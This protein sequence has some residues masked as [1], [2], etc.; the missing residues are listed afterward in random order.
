MFDKD[1][2]I[3]S[4]QR[5]RLADNRAGQMPSLDRSDMAKTVDKQWAGAPAGYRELP[6]FFSTASARARALGVKR[7]TIRV[8]DE[9][10]AR[11][12]RATSQGRV[13]L[14]LAVCA[15]VSK[16]LVTTQDVGRWMLSPQP[17]LRGQSPVEALLDLGDDVIQQIRF[18]LDRLVSTNGSHEPLANDDWEAI[19]SELDPA[20]VRQIRSTY[21]RVVR[22]AVPADLDIYELV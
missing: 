13:A 2:S 10:R 15:A 14:L 12:V 3:P 19:E 9:G 7:D 11:R 8:W 1:P 6:A 22:G 18:A 21:E 5:A 20:V 16:Y 4:S 17:S